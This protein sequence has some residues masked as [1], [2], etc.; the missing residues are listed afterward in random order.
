MADT[1]EEDGIGPPFPPTISAKGTPK[2][3]LEVRTRAD[4]KKPDPSIGPGDAGGEADCQHPHSAKGI[5]STPR[6]RSPDFWLLSITLQSSQPQ[7]ASDPVQHRMRVISPVTVAGPRRIFTGFPFQPPNGAT[8]RQF[9][10]VKTTTEARRLALQLTSDGLPLCYSPRA[11]PSTAF[12]TPNLPRD[13]V[14]AW[15]VFW[16]ARVWPRRRQR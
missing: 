1:E 15:A 16:K 4:N 8:Y 3:W 14:S 5:K 2:R 12:L 10:V 6:G 9:S 11:K 13:T 7:R